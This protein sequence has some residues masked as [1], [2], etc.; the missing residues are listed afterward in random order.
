MI[1]ERLIVG[2]HKAIIGKTPSIILTNPK[3][4]HN[5]AGAIRA[6]SCFGFKQVWYTGNRVSL[7]GEQRLPREER[8]KGY[9]EV[10]LYQFDYPFDCFPENTV[11]VAIEIVENSESLIDFEHPENAVYVF[12]PEDGSINQVV[13]RHCHR[14]VTIPTRHCTNLSSAV[15]LIMYDRMSK[16]VRAGL[17]ELPELCEDRG[18]WQYDED[19]LL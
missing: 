12:G 15:Y 13:R 1:R 19:K 10:D 7:E 18:W 16:R 2:K 11:P 3:Y 14:F 17:E 4:P 8:M 5:V 6:S 9:A